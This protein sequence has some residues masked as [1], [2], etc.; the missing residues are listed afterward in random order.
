MDCTLPGLLLR[1][2]YGFEGSFIHAVC[3]ERVALYEGRPDYITFSQI[4]PSLTACSKNGVVSLQNAIYSGRC[5][6]LLR[7]PFSDIFIT[8]PLYDNA[9]IGRISQHGFFLLEFV[10]STSVVF[11]CFCYLMRKMFVIL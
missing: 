8:N 1:S 11:C 5:S 9:Y 2:V 6:S 4:S 10:C 7:P 3:N